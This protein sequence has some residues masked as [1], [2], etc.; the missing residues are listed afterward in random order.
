MIKWSRQK[1]HSTGVVNWLLKR[2]YSKQENQTTRKRKKHAVRS[3]RYWDPITSPSGRGESRESEGRTA[4]RTTNVQN[5]VTASEGRE[6]LP[7]SDG[8]KEHN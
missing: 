1:G 8:R 7:D 5:L 4:K 3:P 6:S 2:D